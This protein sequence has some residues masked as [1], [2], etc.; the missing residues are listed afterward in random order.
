MKKTAVGYIRARKFAGKWTA[1]ARAQRDQIYDYADAEGF[2]VVKMFVEEQRFSIHKQTG[3]RR[4]FNALKFCKE[5]GAAFIYVDIGRWRRNPVLHE[6]LTEI[7]R[8]KGTKDERP[9][10]V[11]SIPAERRTI[12]LIER[13]AREE[14]YYESFKISKRKRRVVKT[15]SPI[16]QWKV[17]NKIGTKRFNNF[18]HLYKGVEPIY[19]VFDKHADDTVND[20][21]DDLHRGHYLTVDGK[22]WNKDNVRKTRLVIQSDDFRG[23]VKVCEEE[24][25]D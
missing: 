15:L 5:S 16:E 3:A 14:E 21:V 9:Y 1:D 10:S 23:F 12:E 18:K 22:R 11:V 24:K 19:K 4:F 6:T 13:Q 7:E 8:R 2:K 25:Q 20:I 17:D